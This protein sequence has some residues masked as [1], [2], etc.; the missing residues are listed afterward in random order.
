MHRI[1]TANRRGD[2]AVTDKTSLSY[3]DA[4]VDIDAGNALVDRIKGVV[5]QTRR[6][7]VMGGLGGFG[8]L[9]A[10]PQKYRE[11]ILVSGTDGVG[12]KLR[13]AM[14]LKRHDT[15]GIDLV[16]MCVNDLVVQGAEPLFFLDY[17]ATGKLDVDT[18]ASVITGIAEGCKQSGCAL[19]GGETA[20]MPGMYHGEDYDVAGFCVGVV[21]KSEIIDGSKVQSG[22]ALIALG[23]SGPHSNGYSLVRKILEVSNTDP[24]TTDL[25]GKPLADHLLEPTKIYVKSVLELIEK[26]DVHAIAHLTGG[27]FWENIPRVLPEGMQAVID[28]SSWQWPAVFSWLQQAG[29]VSRHEMYRTFNCGVGMVI[30]LPEESVEQAIALLTAAGEKAWKIGK[31]TASSDE[32][33]VVIN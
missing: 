13:L 14:D 26:I 21:E 12:T 30:A 33:Q 25:E 16:A 24:T 17:F 6:P 11:P 29:N 15:I 32:Q 27:G 7:E 22:D 5:K 2:R 19:V 8:A 3:K 18:A 28:E 31:L 23:A 20:E 10:L 4:G 9:C 1:Q